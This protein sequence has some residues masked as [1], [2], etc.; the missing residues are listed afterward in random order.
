MRVPKMRAAREDRVSLN[1]SWETTRADIA[2]QREFG[3]PTQITN[4]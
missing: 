3:S 4:R 1:C 2:A